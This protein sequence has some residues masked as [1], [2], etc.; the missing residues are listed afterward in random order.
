MLLL[1]FLAVLSRDYSARLTLLRPLSSPR[2]PTSYSPSQ[3]P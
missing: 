1:L 2:P 3:A